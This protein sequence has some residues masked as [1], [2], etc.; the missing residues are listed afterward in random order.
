MFT[1]QQ[2]LSVSSPR[3]SR[4]TG[5]L[6]T[7]FL[8]AARALVPGAKPGGGLASRCDG[9]PLVSCIPWCHSAVVLEEYQGSLIV[10]HDA[11]RRAPRSAVRQ[12]V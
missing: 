11:A 12:I 10:P 5:I 4:D 1:L 9:G 2:C 3:V 7:C 6:R 8:C